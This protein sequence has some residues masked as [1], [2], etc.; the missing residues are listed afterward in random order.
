MDNPHSGM[1]MKE[2]G[3]SYEGIKR[4]GDR[5]NQ[6]LCDIV[7]YGLLKEDYLNL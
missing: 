3:M 6:G 1:V 2:C 7:I 5:N 4:Q